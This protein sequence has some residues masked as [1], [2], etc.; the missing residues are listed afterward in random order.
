MK[1]FEDKMSRLEEINVLIRENSLPFSE[2]SALFEEGMKLAQE[3]ESELDQTER[4]I[5]L[6]SEDGS[7]RE[8]DPPGGFLPGESEG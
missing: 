4:K 3:L 7:E 1:N 5:V 2:M 6:L 8:F